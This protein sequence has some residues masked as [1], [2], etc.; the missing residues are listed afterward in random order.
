MQ[1]GS[2]AVPEGREIVPIINDLLSLPFALKLA[3][4]DHHPPD[5]ISFVPNH[6]PSARPFESFTEIVNPAN[7]KE[8]Y[9][10]RLWPDHCVQG[11][12][13]NALLPSL[14]LDKVDQVILKG[15]DPRV[16]MYSAFRSP[17]RDPP[18]ESAVSD[19]ARVLREAG[20]TDVVVAGLAGDYCVKFSAMDS[21]EEGWRTVV[22]EDGLRCVHG[23]DGWEATKEELVVKGVEVVSLDWVKE[24]SACE[25][26]DFFLQGGRRGCPMKTYT[27]SMQNLIPEKA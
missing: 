18:L 22:V 25:I 19:L 14:H 9:S 20:V 10:S 5:H 21:A 6:G 3:T 12:P 8:T 11:T 4:K 24:V 13:G 2:L 1:N 27:C 26:V 16:E 23:R 7:P 15:C 17:L